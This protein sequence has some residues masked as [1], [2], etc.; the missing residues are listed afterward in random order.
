MLLFAATDLKQYKAWTW[1]HTISYC[2]LYCPLQVVWAV[3]CLV[4]EEG[5]DVIYIKPN[6][7]SSISCTLEPCLTLSQFAENTR[8]EHQSVMTLFF[9]PGDHNLDWEISV[10]NISKISMIANSS[11]VNITCQPTTYFKF[12][13]IKYLLMR[14]LNFIGCSN[15]IMC[16]NYF[17][18]FF[19][20]NKTPV[21]QHWIYFKPIRRLQTALSWLTSLA[22]IMVLS[23]S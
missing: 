2:Y 5:G 8:L 3:L 21:E 12:Y 1:S 9:L 17:F 4:S 23:K 13:K 7:S 15:K 18:E 6:S 11:Y 10:S 16:V 20:A 19:W 14:E 22:A